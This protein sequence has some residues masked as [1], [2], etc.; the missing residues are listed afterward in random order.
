MPA[1]GAISLGTDMTNPRELQMRRGYELARLGEVGKHL[2]AHGRCLIRFHIVDD[3]DRRFGKL[4]RFHMDDVADED[5]RL[6][7]VRYGEE[8][9]ARCVSR[10]EVRHDAGQDGFVVG[11]G[12]DLAGLCKNADRLFSLVEIT[13]VVTRSLGV[14]WVEEE[15]DVI[16]LVLRG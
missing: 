1:V 4:H 9:R 13:P 7:F 8:G 2:F 16:S 12:F 11:E 5:D 6:S 3:G 15:V 14:G 10:V